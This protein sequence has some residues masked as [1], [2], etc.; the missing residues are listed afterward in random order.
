MRESATLEPIAYEPI[1]NDEGRRVGWNAPAHERERFDNPPYSTERP[2]PKPRDLAALRAVL[3][4]WVFF[5][6]H[7]ESLLETK[8]ADDPLQV[9]LLVTDLIRQAENG[10]VSGEL[11]G[12][13]AHKL[14]QVKGG[15]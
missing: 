7:L 11:G 2:A 3:D 1:F 4:P 5:S 10:R 8:Y 9:S 12:L 15:Q 13:L 6:H 14:S